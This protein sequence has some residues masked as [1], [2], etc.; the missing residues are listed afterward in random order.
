MKS[1]EICKCRD[2]YKN[3]N[4]GTGKCYKCPCKKFKPKFKS[5]VG[6]DISKPKGCGKDIEIGKNIYECG[7]KGKLCE[8]CKPQN[9]GK[10]LSSKIRE[11]DIKVMNDDISLLVYLNLRTNLD[12]EFI[13]KILT[14]YVQTMRWTEFKKMINKHAGE[15]IVK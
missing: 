6:K 5:W 9:H 7:Y 15:G 12:K 13:K 2:K 1:E 8:D 3:H 10:T 4:K 14:D 11:L